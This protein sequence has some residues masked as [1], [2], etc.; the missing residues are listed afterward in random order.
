MLAFG[1]IFEPILDRPIPRRVFPKASLSNMSF[2]VTRY[3]A[4]IPM[5]RQVVYPFAAPFTRK[6]LLAR[7]LDKGP[8]L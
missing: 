2:F 5:K 1:T 4:A 6:T 8:S 3:I 7:E